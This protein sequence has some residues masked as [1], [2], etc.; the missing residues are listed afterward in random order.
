LIN[1]QNLLFGL[2]TSSTPSITS[3]LSSSSTSP[4]NFP[5][6]KSP[7]NIRKSPSNTP[8]LTKYSTAAL[9][10]NQRQQKEGK[11]SPAH[12]SEAPQQA[13]N[14]LNFEM[15]QQQN[16]PFDPQILAR[17]ETVRK[18]IF[19]I[20]YPPKIFFFLGCCNK[21]TITIATTRK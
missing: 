5:V 19:L 3:S 15:T 21:P 13:I 20:F 9:L 4:P 2:P 6:Q 10:Q 7:S 16:L 18:K 8:S 14:N 17:L 1:N 12:G 11:L